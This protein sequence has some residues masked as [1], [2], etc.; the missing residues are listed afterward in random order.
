[1]KLC[2]YVSALHVS[3]RKCFLG[4]AAQGTAEVWRWRND[5]CPAGYVGMSAFSGFPLSLSYYSVHGSGLLLVCL[6]SLQVL[7]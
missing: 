1:M 4:L 2:E 3:G 7:T 5:P 6:C